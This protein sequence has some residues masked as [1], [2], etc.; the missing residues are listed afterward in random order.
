M[1]VERHLVV[2]PAAATALLN[3][4][5]GG[6]TLR[7]VS[8]L[9]PAWFRPQSRMQRWTNDMRRPSPSFGAAGDRP[10][11]RH[12]IAAGVMAWAAAPAD[13]GAAAAVHANLLELLP[14]CGGT[15]F[16][17]APPAPP[18]PASVEAVASKLAGRVLDDV[19]QDAAL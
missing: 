11:A 1:A 15:G 19:A 16:L 3:L 2:V 9:K 6:S 7:G 10:A 18:A 12:A 5:V 4:P 14:R 17:A 13:D 8:G